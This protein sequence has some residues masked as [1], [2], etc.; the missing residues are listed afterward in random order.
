MA[1]AKVAM[2]T[3]ATRGIGRCGALDLASRGYDV[4][5]T[6]RTVHEGDAKE[7]GVVIPGSLDATAEQIEARG[8]RCL[9]IA[10]D[11]MDRAS[12][13]AGLER[14]MHEWGRIDVLVNNAPYS[15]PGTDAKFLDIDCELATKVVEADYSNQICITQLALPGMLERGAGTIINLG[16]GSALVPP[17]A[18]AGDGGWSLVHCAGKA[19]F[20]Q[21]AVILNVEFRDRGIRAFTL[22]PGYT[23]TERRRALNRKD[24]FIE[25]FRGDPPEVAGA[26]I[27][28]LAD[29]AA[30][31]SLLGGM[32]HAQAVCK[33]HGLVP[34]WPP[35]AVG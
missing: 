6:G 7:A 2:V 4:V 28:W 10:M 16:S 12:I 35:A 30:A 14:V 13:R 34:G 24:E 5:V 11:I 20:H 29:E 31:D 3:G 19:A 25:H 9:P 21:M 33:R 15:G 23:I 18:P 22:E 27:G 1:E 26:V 17:P 8:R 32:V